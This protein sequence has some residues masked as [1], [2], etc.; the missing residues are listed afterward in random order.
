[1]AAAGAI[2]L[3]ACCNLA[4]LMLG[5]AVGRTHEMAIRLALGSGR[6][7]LIRQLLTEAALLSLFGTLAALVVGRWGAVALASLVGNDQ[8]ALE[9]DWRLLGAALVTTVLATCLFGLVPAIV[10]TGVSLRVAMQRRPRR[11]FRGALVVA[12]LSLSLLLLSAAGMLMR[13]L[14]NLRFQDFG[15]RAEQ[16]LIAD[17]PWE[18]SPTMM[19]RYAALAGPLEDRLRA[20]PGVRSAAIAGFG[21]LGGDQHTGSVAAPGRP[22]QPGDNN[23]IVHAGTGYFAAMGIDIVQGR[24]FTVDDRAG[25]PAVA[26]LSETAAR[27]IFGGASAV[28]RFVSQASPYDA[29]RALEVVG[30]AR[31]VRF[32]G[33]S[34]PF[35]FLLYVPI[36]QS[37]APITAVV[38]RTAGDAAS[39]AANVRAVL[40]DLDPEL[41]IGSI[42]SVSGKIDGM[43]LRERS[44]ALLST[45]FGI[46]ALGLTAIGIYGVISYG[47]E[48]RTREIGIRIA[49]GARSAQVSRMVL[50]EL[51]TLA[52]LGAIL[53]GAGAVAAARALRGMLFGI[54]PNDYSSVLLAGVL[55]GVVAAVAAWIPARRGARIDPM[56]AL[57]QE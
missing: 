9:F 2:L 28:G 20:L 47:V 33:P 16:A 36:A 26:I 42:R 45:C 37:P 13:S 1:M 12:Q 3:I 35:G 30:V 7:R 23:R 39:V 32:A 14:W 50:K 18:F 31:D 57:R 43:L 51:A 48:Q 10:S 41:A 4:N 29:H 17:L 38:V 6:A 56:D 40:H 24:P 49:L 5:R 53:G 22:S 52:V 19:A 8:F 25:A 55:L 11:V 54:G 44:T 27:Q 46:L 15:F 34:D 21:P